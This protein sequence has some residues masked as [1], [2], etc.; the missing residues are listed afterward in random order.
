[1]FLSSGVSSPRNC[2]LSTTRPERMRSML[3]TRKMRYLFRRQPSRADEVVLALC[4]VSNGNA[5]SFGRLDS[6]RD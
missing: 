5:D 6:G 1:M 4:E 3:V 2:N